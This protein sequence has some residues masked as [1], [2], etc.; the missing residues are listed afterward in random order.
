MKIHYSYQNYQNLMIIIL[1]RTYFIR[2]ACL[3]NR[4]KDSLLCV[5]FLTY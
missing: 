4:N 1:D 3:S 2:S 5:N